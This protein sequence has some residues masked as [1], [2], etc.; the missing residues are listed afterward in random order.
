MVSSCHL[1]AAARK[2]GWGEHHGPDRDGGDA[3]GF[4]MHT[5]KMEG[6]VL[7]HSRG[8]LCLHRSRT[9]GQ[10]RFSAHMR[11]AAVVMSKDVY[12]GLPVMSKDVYN[13]LPAA[14]RDNHWLASE[15]ARQRG[16]KKQMIPE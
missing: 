4:P 8:H 3:L 10:G 6:R 2:E 14:E 7:T 15:V 13:S 11:P 5:L 9:P 16:G 1:I 12:N